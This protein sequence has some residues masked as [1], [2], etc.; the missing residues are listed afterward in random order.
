VEWFVN[1]VRR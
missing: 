1:S